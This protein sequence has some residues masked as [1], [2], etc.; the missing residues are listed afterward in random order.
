MGTEF[1]RLRRK[2]ARWRF[3]RA[4]LT[5][6]A[7]ALL[8]SGGL[9]A[10][11]KL[12]STNAH[13]ILCLALGLG[14]G[15]VAAVIRWVLLRRSDI[16]A[17]EQID[18][19]HNLRERVQTM[20]FFREEESPM[21]QMQRQDTEEK[22]L[23]VST[24]GVKK[25]SMLG[26]FLAV[27]AATAVLVLG[28]ILPARAEVEPPVYKEPDYAAT[29]WQL[30][31]L[32]ALIV[33]VQESNMAQQAKDETVL[34]L[35]SLRDALDKTITVTAFK[36]QVIEVITNVYMATDLVN[37]NDDMH[38]VVYTVDHEQAQLLSYVVGMPRNETFNGDVEDLGYQLGKEENLSTIAQF[39]ADL[40]AQVAKIPVDYIPQNHYTAED[41]LYLATAALAEGLVEVGAMIEGGSEATDVQNRLGEVIHAF[42]SQANLG[43]EQQRVTKEECVYVVENLCTI[44][45]LSVNEC[46]KDPD[47]VYSKSGKEDDNVSS[48]GGAGDGEM[49]YAGDEQ[50]YDYKQD[51]HVSYTELIAEY[52]AAML[53]ASQ[54]GKISEEMVEY[55]LKYFSQLYTG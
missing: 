37:S 20:I 1:L 16:R 39:G 45:G 42:K 2:N 22:L 24:Y 47:P 48:S 54:E 44:F 51:K 26:H 25:L 50:V 28:L 3:G 17:A 43:L 46:P 27:V 5:G 9:M 11:F 49:Q 13:M 18:Q 8:L 35:Q 55:I 32:E 34:Q 36:N 38:D 15:L 6:M 14:L 41:P 7:V 23:S 30:A 12:T 52:Y 53:Q 40:K 29:E 19:E 4:V 31:S 33:H 21:L 10:F